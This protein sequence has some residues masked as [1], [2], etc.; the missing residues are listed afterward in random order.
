MVNDIDLLESL[1]KNL[2][3]IDDKIMDF[4]VKRFEIVSL[5]GKYKKKNKV[6]VIQ[7]HRIEYVINKSK[8]VAKKNNLDPDFLKEIYIIIISKACKLENEIIDE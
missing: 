2:D 5:I 1:R 8:I 6:P 4:L 3:D 7:S